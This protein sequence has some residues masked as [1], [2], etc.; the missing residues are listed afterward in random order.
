MFWNKDMLNHRC[1]W[2]LFRMLIGVVTPCSLVVF[3]KSFSNSYIEAQVVWVCFIAILLSD[4]WLPS[5][6]SFTAWHWV[7]QLYHG[8]GKR[9]LCWSLSWHA[10]YKGFEIELYKY[11]Y[12]SYELLCLRRA[13]KPN[14]FIQLTLLNVCDYASIHARARARTHTHT[15]THI[16]HWKC[17]LGASKSLLLL[18]L[19]CFRGTGSHTVQADL[20][21]DMFTHEPPLFIRVTLL[22]VV[23]QALPCKRHKC[24]QFCYVKCVTSLCHSFVSVLLP[25]C[26]ESF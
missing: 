9:D 17:G 8:V 1:L 14:L 12:I 21:T 26:L 18:K 5:G 2:A 4:A 11:K 24:F 13:Y 3:T 10:L 6:T 16:A 7:I 22:S 19:T 25:L 23:S 15:H 20:C